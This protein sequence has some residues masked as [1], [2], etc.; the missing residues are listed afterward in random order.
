MA[1]NICDELWEELGDAIARIVY[2]SEEE[3]KEKGAV[4]YRKDG[5][6][7]MGNIVTG[8]EVE[9]EE[10]VP[11]E[12]FGEPVGSFHTHPAEFFGEEKHF[13]GLTGRRPSEQEI[14]FTPQDLMSA[15][16]ENNE[17]ICV[18]GDGFTL[19]C[20]SGIRESRK[21]V[22]VGVFL[23]IIRERM[24]LMQRICLEDAEK[25]GLNYCKRDIRQAVVDIARKEKGYLEP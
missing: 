21:T 3:Y 22:K 1:E 20:L 15:F 11:E 10:L 25:L 14:G 23:D 17:F 12:G 13:I 6:L 2:E 5:K 19:H 18:V 4:I 7:I 8:T 16:L 24:E 9:L